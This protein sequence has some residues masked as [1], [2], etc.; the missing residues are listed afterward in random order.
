MRIR[1]LSLILLLAPL[2]FGQTLVGTPTSNV[3]LSAST[4]SVTAVNVGA[5][6]L[7]AV[8][9]YDS[10]SGGTSHYNATTDTG[11]SNTFAA[12]TEFGNSGLGFTRWAVAKNTNANASDTITV[13]FSG[14]TQA[15][16]DVTVWQYSGAD[17]SAPVD[18]VAGSVMNTPAV[19]YTSPAFTTTA[20]NEK[21]LMLVAWPGGGNPFTAGAGYGN[22]TT[23][24][25]NNLAS[26]DET[27][28]SIQ[29]G[30]TA[31]MTASA[32]V[33][34][35]G[36]V[37]TIKASGL[38][39]T[40][41]NLLSTQ[42]LTF[43]E[44]RFG[45]RAPAQLITANLSLG[46][47]SWTRTSI[48]QVY[49]FF[50]DASDLSTGSTSTSIFVVLF[51][52]ADSQAV[53]NGYTDVAGIQF[54]PGAI[55]CVINI[56]YNVVANGNASNQFTNMLGIADSA[57][58][59]ATTPGGPVTGYSLIPTTTIGSLPGGSDQRPANGAT[60]VS[61]EFGTSI[62]R[63]SPTGYVHLYSSISPLNSDNTVIAATPL[64]G[65]GLA[66]IDTGTC[67]AHNIVLAGVTTIQWD[68]AWSGH[69]PLNNRAW[70]FLN[71][72]VIE[73]TFNFGTWTATST[74]PHTFSGATVIQN[75][76]TYD[77]NNQGYLSYVTDKDHAGST[78][79]ANICAVKIV[80]GAGSWPDNP[81]RDLSLEYPDGITFPPNNTGITWDVDS[82]TGKIYMNA[83]TGSGQKHYGPRYS[84]T[85]GDAA[86]AFEGYWGISP[87]ATITGGGFD[88]A[89]LPLGTACTLALGQATPDTN[90]IY[91]G[92]HSAFAGD[93][94][95]RQYWVVGSALKEP[96]VGAA[97]TVD[98]SF[99][100]ATDTTSKYMPG[101]GGGLDV[102]LNVG[103][104]AGYNG[105]MGCIQDWC[106]TTM[107]TEVVTSWK[108]TNVTVAAGTATITLDCP[109]GSQAWNGSSCVASANTFV[110]GNSAVIGNVGGCT[111]LNSATGW[112]GGSVT[113]S[114]ST[115]TITGTGAS[116]GCYTA[117]TGTIAKNT[118]PTT[119][120]YRDE[121]LL[122]HI[123][124]GSTIE[125]R[126]LG[127]RYQQNFS[128]TYTEGN[129]YTL[130]GCAL[131]HDL[132]FAVCNSNG[133][134][135]D[136]DAIL[137]MST[138]ILT[139]STATGI[140]TGSILR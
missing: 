63:C 52:N 64:R 60:M 97:L 42:S 34:A 15:R 38:P 28:T 43:N 20:A 31:S 74:T 82:R 95:G 124:N 17:T 99:S 109:S 127:N 92:S 118:Y 9:S 137:L 84:F 62:K 107:V 94:A 78:A 41:A 130:V 65:G 47:T 53:A 87:E 16:I 139:P 4:C 18:Q 79:H 105:E 30:V 14:V 80:P 33:Q 83:N 2:G 134:K 50:S 21:L 6:N 102:I 119:Y 128:D 55:N 3:C 73:I 122:L 138:G 91:T 113:V 67:T 71:N 58:T 75:G 11:S 135:P 98:A 88:G 68:F 29:T 115:V 54:N 125:T 39:A 19:T 10:G 56:T 24:S 110:T 101:A 45:P 13:D 57:L 89:K 59:N 86:L 49:S 8:A 126:R 25:D 36:S 40:C 120:N 111:Q 66:L 123:V 35:V 108:I 26:E 117:S 129:Y 23:T 106:I 93:A 72:T 61:A 46:P 69:V 1:F 77:M 104:G 70:S 51:G 100:S 133:G 12:Q 132:K 96:S 81:C 136:E 116:P 44:P 27:V 48:G 32:S 22:L 85:P 131:S 114:G 103:S 76:A 121:V 5:G 37:L 112:P 140:F 90:C 7:L